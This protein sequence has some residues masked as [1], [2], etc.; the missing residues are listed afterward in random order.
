MKTH[1]HTKAC[2]WMFTAA[3]FIRVKK[4]KQLKCPSADEQT[5][6]IN[7]LSIQWKITQPQQGMKCWV[8]FESIMLSERS[9][10][11]KTTYSMYVFIMKSLEQANQLRQ[12]G[13]ERLP[14]LGRWVRHGGGLLMDM[15]FLFRVMKCPKIVAAQSVIVMTTESHTLSELC[16]MRVTIP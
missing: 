13:G 10:I 16:S 6:C 15:E 2:T 4:S 14:G 11:R 12:K 7:S 5:R 3:L 9:Q 8:N 1:D